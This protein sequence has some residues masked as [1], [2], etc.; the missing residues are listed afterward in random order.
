MNTV[1]VKRLELLDKIRGN[2]TKHRE[3]FLKAQEGYR[4]LVIT[5]LDRMLK[6]ARDGKRIRRTIS[7]PEPQDHTD[8][9]DR[10]ISMLEMSL[11]EIVEIHANEFDMY[12]RDRW[13]W[14][15]IAD[16]TNIAYAAKR[17][18]GIVDTDDD[19]VYR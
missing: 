15:Q 11:D 17:V 10:V 1:K 16:L 6:D 13:G 14:K 4:E 12:V 8:D 19:P 2:R 9:Y 3:L 18:P 5:E 7:M